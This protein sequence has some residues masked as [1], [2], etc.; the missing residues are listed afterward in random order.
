MLKLLLQPT[1]TFRSTSTPHTEACINSKILLGVASNAVITYC[2]ELYPGSVSDKAIVAKSG[3]LEVFKSCDLILADKRFL[4]R[5]IVPEGVSVNTPPFL[6]H[7]R[8]TKSEIKL[9]KDIAWTRNHV[10]RANAC[11]KEYKIL[12]FIPHTL[13]SNTD[14]VVQFCCPLVNS[15]T[16]CS[17]RLWFLWMSNFE[18][19]EPTTVQQE[20]LILLFQLHYIFVPNLLIN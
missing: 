1:W 14:V 20:H 16:P 10:E 17:Q 9:T 12:R 2:S 6:H 15:R 4:I 7:G 19:A 5:D 8:L 11:L 18:F 3:I 13:R